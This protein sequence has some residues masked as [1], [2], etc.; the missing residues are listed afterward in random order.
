MRR[1]TDEDKIDQRK[2]DERV[3]QD[4]DALVPRRPRPFQRRPSPVRLL[5]VELLLRV[6]AAKVRWPLLTRPVGIVVHA[7]RRWFVC[8]RRPPAKQ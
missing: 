8:G 4:L 2:R 1:L 3:L 7:E 6:E 5:K